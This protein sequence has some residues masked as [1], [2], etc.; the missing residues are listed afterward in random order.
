MQGNTAGMGQEN[1]FW[2]ER[3]QEAF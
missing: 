2:G 3:Q 1:G